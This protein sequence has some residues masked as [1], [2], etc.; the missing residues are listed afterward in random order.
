MPSQVSFDFD[1][2]AYS[3]DQ[4]LPVLAPVTTRI[5]EHV[6]EPAAGAKVLD[7][8]CGTG[9]PGLTLAQRFPGVELLG[10]DAAETMVG[11][12]RT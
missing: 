1:R 2:L 7:V 4:M 9:A 3:F 10:I 6:P 11:I 5:I 12:V 8:A